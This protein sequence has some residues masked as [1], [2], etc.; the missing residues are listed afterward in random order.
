MI[1][2]RP[3]GMARLGI[4]LFANSATA[5][6]VEKGGWPAIRVVM[7]SLHTLRAKFRPQAEDD[8]EATSRYLNQLSQD[9]V[10]LKHGSC[11]EIWHSKPWIDY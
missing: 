11:W 2:G 8:E 5:N 6:A 10:M 4:A 3:G 1:A 7:L 9:I